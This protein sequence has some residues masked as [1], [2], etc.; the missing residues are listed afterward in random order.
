MHGPPLTPNEAVTKVLRAYDGCRLQGYG[1]DFAV[2]FVAGKL[3]V[4]E[5]TVIRALAVRERSA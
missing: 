2:G 3:D 1:H 5:P 4:P